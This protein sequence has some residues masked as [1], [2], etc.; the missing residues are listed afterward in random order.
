MTHRRSRCRPEPPDVALVKLKNEGSDSY[1]EMDPDVFLI[2]SLLFH[3][4]LHAAT[5]SR[6]I[7]TAICSI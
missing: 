2:V 6:P 7:K 4:V 5:T 3:D 1:V